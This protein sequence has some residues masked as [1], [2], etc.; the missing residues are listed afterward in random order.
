MSC[1]VEVDAAMPQMDILL[2]DTDQ[3]GDLGV[4][5]ASPSTGTPS[6]LT[7][8]GLLHLYHLTEGSGTVANDSTPNAPAVNGVITNGSWNTHQ[9]VKF[10]TFVGTGDVDCPVTDTFTN[11]LAVGCWFSPSALVDQAEM[12]GLGNCYLLELS[13]TSGAIRFGLHIGG[14]WVYLTAPAGTIP[15][16]G[17][18]FALAVYDG[19]NMYLYVANP[20][21]P[22]ALLTY[23]QVQTGNL[24]SPSG[25]LF[26]GGSSYQ[27]VVNEA[28]IWGRSLSAQEVQELFFGPLLEL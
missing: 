20:N 6:A 8:Q 2:Q 28:M 9:G 10:L 19:A 4:Y 27:G 23:S 3:Y 12:I 15:V 21:V 25:D 16:N 5:Q 24:D 22:N 7:L 13:G 11:K 14:S 18:C 26:L 17:R 1:T